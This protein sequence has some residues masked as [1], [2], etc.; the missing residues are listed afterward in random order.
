MQRLESLS[1]CTV[2]G[3]FFE[4]NWGAFFNMGMGWGFLSMKQ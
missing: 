1:L 3:S 4:W 2:S